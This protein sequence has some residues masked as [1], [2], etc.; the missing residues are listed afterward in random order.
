MCVC[1]CGGGGGGGGGGGWGGERGGS[2][3]QHL[4]YT[5]CQGFGV[6]SSASS[7]YKMLG[8]CS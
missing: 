7:L 8:F 6:G 4:L 3:H 2:G 5:K 1:V